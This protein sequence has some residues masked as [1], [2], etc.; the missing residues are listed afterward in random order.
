MSRESL[1]YLPVDEIMKTK[2]V[3]I[4]KQ[5]I[6][7]LIAY[8]PPTKIGE[9][10]NRIVKIWNRSVTAAG[11]YSPYLTIQEKVR[12]WFRGKYTIDSYLLNEIIVTSNS[13]SFHDVL[14]RITRPYILSL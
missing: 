9:C 13:Q 5:K 3:R 10:S 4:F 6:P 14:P 1:R 12:Q 7:L 11:G 8:R 2:S